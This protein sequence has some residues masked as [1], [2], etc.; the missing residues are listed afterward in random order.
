MP[1]LGVDA[2]VEKM[3]KGAPAASSA[4]ETPS[5]K[6]PVQD[7]SVQNVNTEETPG[8]SKEDGQE[9]LT[10]FEQE[11]IEEFKEEYE[12]A[13]DKKPFL[14]ALKRSY[15]K[16]SKQL[17][18]LGTLRKAIST[19]KEAGVTNEDL[20]DLVNR[21]RGK[22]PETKSTT[23]ESRRGL[24][25][26]MDEATDAEEREK[27]SHARQAMREEME[28]LL[29]ERLDKEVRPLRER[30]E[31]SEREALTSRTQTLE[32]EINEL[33]DKLGYPGSFVETHR[34]TMKHLGLRFP[35]KS[36]E[37]LL[38]DVAGFQA[39]KSV[40]AKMSAKAEDAPVVR[41]PAASVVKK[42]APAELSQKRNGSISIMDALD[43]LL[44]PKR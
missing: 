23:P 25:R 2:T 38:V 12:Q 27:V 13:S 15:R 1:D 30:L 8:V 9:P 7:T 6:A 39:V 32:Q 11:L 41:K 19:L 34:E 26:F 18:E 40:M 16:Q 20:I 5:A 33:E 35:K 3:L 29:A 37:D 10:A 14:N 22:S 43:R 28:D 17:N 42:P 44:K 24:A 4:D 21:R 31:F 36:A